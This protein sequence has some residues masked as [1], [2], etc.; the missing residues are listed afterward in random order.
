MRI[1]NLIEFKSKL[2]NIKTDSK[3]S[4]KQENEI[5]SIRNLYDA[6][7][8]FKFYNDYY[9]MIFKVGYDATH[10]KRLKVLTP[11]KVLQRLQIALAQINAG[12]TSENVLNEI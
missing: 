1:K 4:E 3:K 6:Q 2:S 10:G 7:N 11:K 12:N 8:E 5:K 9:S